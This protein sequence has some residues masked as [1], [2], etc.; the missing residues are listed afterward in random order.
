MVTAYMLTKQ[1]N[2]FINIFFKKHSYLIWKKN[3]LQWGSEMS[4]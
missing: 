3:E 2:K 4:I 1:L